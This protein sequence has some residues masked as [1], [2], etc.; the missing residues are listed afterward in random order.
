[1]FKETEV[2]LLKYGMQCNANANANANA[3]KC[4]Y[5]LHIFLIF[6]ALL[7]IITLRNLTVSYGKAACKVLQLIWGLWKWILG[8]FKFNIWWY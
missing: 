1:M 4:M 8:S 3:M 2:I 6:F 7:N 5:V